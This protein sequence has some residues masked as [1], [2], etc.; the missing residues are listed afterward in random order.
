LR[1]FKSF[2]SIYIIIIIDDNKYILYIF[3]PYLF[4]FYSKNR[5]LYLNILRTFE[6]EIRYI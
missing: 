1:D 3:F 4:I 5:Y 6:A 2:L